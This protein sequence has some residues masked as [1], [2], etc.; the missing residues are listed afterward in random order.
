MGKKI[1]I[2]EDHIA[3]LIGYNGGGIRCIDMA[4]RCANSALVVREIFTH[5]VPNSK[6]RDLK[7]QHRI[8]AKIILGCFN[9]RKPTS[10]PDYINID[11]QFL[12]YFIAKK[13]KINLA[14]LLFH[15]LKTSVKETREE[16]K[17]KRDWIPFGRLISDILTENRLIEHLTEAQEISSLEP[18]VGKQLN[19]K[20]L[21]KMK[22]IENIRKE[23]S[24]TPHA[25][26]TSRRVPLDNF[27]MFSEIDSKLV[28]V[29]RYLDACKADG[30]DPDL[31][32]KDLHQQTPEVTLKKTKKRKVVSEGSSQQT[33]KK[34]GILSSVNV[35]NSSAVPTFI[36]TP[37]S[38]EIPIPTIDDTEPEFDPSESLTLRR[39]RAKPHNPKPTTSTEPELEKVP[40]EKDQH[41]SAPH[42]ENQNPQP[43][44]PLSPQPETTHSSEPETP[45]PPSPQPELNPPSP[46]HES[47]P[48]PEFQHSEAQTPEP[49]SSES[50]EP[51]P[52]A[53]QFPGGTTVNIPQLPSSPEITPP[54]SPSSPIII[55]DSPTPSPKQ[56]PDN[57]NKTFIDLTVLER[58]ADIKNKTAIPKPKQPDVGSSILNFETDMQKWISS[59]KQASLEVIDPAVSD[60]L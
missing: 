44:T 60:H 10:S 54:N 32:I 48:Q 26:I 24:V 5:G 42:T 19:A 38:F 35:L 18:S 59:L 4:D 57:H 34:R 51:Q 45:Q 12:I 50:S 17:T 20:N 52:L 2:T 21:K 36:P 47:S 13:S 6:I 58:L 27:P 39:S 16:E 55:P 37:A 43:E 28:I 22:L 46:P 14:H 3:R 29:L 15:H 31:N 9:H 30:T 23:P 8:W 56:N 41:S 25:E 49:Q 11:Q 53:I 33:P 7:D 1:V 40:S